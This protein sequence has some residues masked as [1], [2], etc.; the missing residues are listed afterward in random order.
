MPRLKAKQDQN[1]SSQDQDLNLCKSSLMPLSSCK[2]LLCHCTQLSSSL[3]WWLV[4]IIYILHHLLFIFIYIQ[5]CMSKYSCQSK[6]TRHKRKWLTIST[7]GML[8]KRFHHLPSQ[9][10]YQVLEPMRLFSLQAVA[11]RTLLP[12]HSHLHPSTIPTHNTRKEAYIPSVGSRA[13]SRISCL[14]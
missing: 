4:T 3:F 6:R 1:A 7:P 8:L 10:G 12:C 2:T 11:K 5:K 9:W 14:W 13:R